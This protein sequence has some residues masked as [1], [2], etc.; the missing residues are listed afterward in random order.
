MGVSST[1]L[2]LLALILHPQL[3]QE[4]EDLLPPSPQQRL[5]PGGGQLGTDG[6]GHVGAVGTQCAP[7]PPQH[8][9]MHQDPPYD[10]QDPSRHFKTP[11]MTQGPPKIA[12]MTSPCNNMLP[13]PPTTPRASPVTPQDC[14]SDHPKPPPSLYTLTTTPRPLPDPHVPPPSTPIALRAPPGSPCLPYCTTQCCPPPIRAPCAPPGFPSCLGAPLA[15]PGAP[16]SPPSSHLPV[17][18]ALLQG[19]D[20]AE[21]AELRTEQQWG[22]RG[23]DGGTPW[24]HC[25]LLGTARAQHGDRAAPSPRGRRL[26]SSEGFSP[27]GPA[28]L[29]W[30]RLLSASSSSPNRRLRL[31][32][33]SSS[34][35]R[36]WLRLFSASSSASRLWLRLLSAS[37]S[38]PSMW[39]RLLSASSS[40]PRAW[41]RL[42]S[43]SS[44]LLKGGWRGSRAYWEHWGEPGGKWGAAC[45][46]GGPLP[47]AGGRGTERE[48]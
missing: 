15:M 42:L 11:Q 14:P 36:L 34:T 5:Q 21:S 25:D 26:T 41:L 13:D 18:L 4:G 31:L 22:L 23:G 37:S 10:T 35:S 12:P 16:Q 8:L 38:T 7:P 30:P 32:S 44:I 39:L 27:S 24:G 2:H 20:V 46:D 33:T 43:T 17:Q 9:R 1:H 40:A 48:V 47:G 3:H 6:G 45:D 29:A 28:P 19:Q